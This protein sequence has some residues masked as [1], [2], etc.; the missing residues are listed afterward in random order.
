ML[1]ASPLFDQVRAIVRATH[2][3]Y[4]GS[5]Y[6]DG[7]AGDRIPMG[8]RIMLVAESYLALSITGSPDPLDELRGHAGSRL[9]PAVLSAL[10]GVG[11]CG[12]RWPRR[13]HGVS[14]GAGR[15]RSWPTL[16]PPR[17]NHV[18]GST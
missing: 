1:G 3:H 9:D 2:E 15:L 16:P 4:D 10:A 18:H 6:P 11:P 13:P 8:A 14:R 17:P 5:G 12:R 7:L